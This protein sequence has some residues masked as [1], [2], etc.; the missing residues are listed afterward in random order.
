MEAI[1]QDDFDTMA[2]KMNENPLE[3]E[4]L[5]VPPGVDASKPVV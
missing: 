3:Y 1:L 2:N 4:P 5:K